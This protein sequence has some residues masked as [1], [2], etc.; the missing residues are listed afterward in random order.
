MLACL[1]TLPT[2]DASAPGRARSVHF[3]FSEVEIAARLTAGRERSDASL[4]RHGFRSSG[5]A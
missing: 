3:G 2:G 5:P 1:P 4:G